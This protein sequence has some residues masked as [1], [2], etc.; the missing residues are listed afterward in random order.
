M[1]IISDVYFRKTDGIIFT[2]FLAL[3]YSVQLESNEFPLSI[4]TEHRKEEASASP[5]I[6]R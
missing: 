4:R 6:A 3:M 5:L 2:P 1:N